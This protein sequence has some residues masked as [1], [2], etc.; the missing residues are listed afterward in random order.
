MQNA[1][2]GLTKQPRPLAM[3]NF[4]RRNP[5]VFWPITHSPKRSV[6]S[7]S[8]RMCL[9]LRLLSHFK[10]PTGPE[11]PA[12]AAYSTRRHSPATLAATALPHASCASQR[13]AA[14]RIAPNSLRRLPPV[15]AAKSDAEKNGIFWK[16]SKVCGKV[17]QSKQ[18]EKSEA[19]SNRS[20]PNASINRLTYGQA[21]W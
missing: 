7:C 3:M 15:I 2:H 4:C 14:G 17:T 5:V 20:L 11:S 18:G 12:S 9:E 1:C 16:R 6:A 8:R 21:A 10:T 13:A 19:H